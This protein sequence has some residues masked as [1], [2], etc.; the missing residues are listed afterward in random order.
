MG[1][2]LQLVVAQSTPAASRNKVARDCS[3]RQKILPAIPFQ[4]PYRDKDYA[5]TDASRVERKENAFSESVDS[6]KCVRGVI[7]D[8][9]GHTKQ[10]AGP[11]TALPV[12]I[13]PVFD[14]T[15]S[16]RTESLQNFY[17][18]ESDDYH[19]WC[20]IVNPSH[21]FPRWRV[22]RRSESVIVLDE[23]AKIALL[24]LDREPEHEPE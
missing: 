19:V 17:E 3:P 4:R 18:N 21:P 6:K 2:Q 14:K 22:Q 23:V 7:F 5:K 15:W 24:I 12:D 1:S 10:I 16:I 13:S 20:G 11:C 9:D 8:M